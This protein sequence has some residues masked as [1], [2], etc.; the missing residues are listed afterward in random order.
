M[1]SLWLLTAFGASI[2]WG[3]TYVLDQRVLQTLSPVQLLMVSSLFGFVFL[4]IYSFFSGDMETLKGNLG[5]TDLKWLIAVFIVSNCAGLLIM[6]SIKASNASLAAII[7][8]SYPLFTVAF[9]YLL[10]KNYSLH[11]S[12]AV[13]AFFILTG[14]FVIAYFNK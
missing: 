14:S 2:L 9:G 12:F 6:A 13:G 11:W 3:L 1:N 8:I 4:A 10:I 7:E 5:K